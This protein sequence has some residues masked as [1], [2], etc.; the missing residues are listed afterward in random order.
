MANLFEYMK[1][2]YERLEK[3]TK[4]ALAAKSHSASLRD[5][6]FE[7]FGENF[8]ITYDGTR[9]RELLYAI[10]ES[11][12]HILLMRLVAQDHIRNAALNGGWPVLKL[13][14]A[15]KEEPNPE[16]PGDEAR[17]DEQPTPTLKGKNYNKNKKEATRRKK[18]RQANRATTDQAEAAEKS[19]EAVEE[20]ESNQ[21]A[22]TEHVHESTLDNENAASLT[23]LGQPVNTDNNIIPTDTSIKASDPPSSPS[24]DIKPQAQQIATVIEGDTKDAKPS[25]ETTPAKLE[26]L[27]GQDTDSGWEEIPESLLLD[28]NQGWKQVEGKRKKFK[29][30]LRGKASHNTT[31]ST[32][33]D[34]VSFWCSDPHFLT[35]H[36][37]TFSYIHF[38]IYSL[39]TKS[40]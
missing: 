27:K 30:D 4:D 8:E 9:L 40:N 20:A 25:T 3:E 12:M 29:K 32:S 11:S 10:H 5:A 36:F 15:S 19:S 17:K 16:S 14:R 31:A 34:V 13:R 22:S 2:A 39:F 38:F 33:S 28:D 7:L 1:S 26:D 23:P 35:F 6:A 37:F 18:L 24:S 21:F